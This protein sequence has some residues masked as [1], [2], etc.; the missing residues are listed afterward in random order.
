VKGEGCESTALDTVNGSIII[1]NPSKYTGTTKMIELIGATSKG[2]D[3]EEVT[4]QSTVR[5][6][7][8]CH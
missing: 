5:E 4:N 2:N 3:N 7:K 6:W 8:G 1:S